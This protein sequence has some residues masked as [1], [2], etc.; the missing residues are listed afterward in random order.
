MSPLVN[1]AQQDQ[2]LHRTL[3]EIVHRFVV[4][5]F[6]EIPLPSNLNIL[7]L[8]PPRHLHSS[9]R[10]RITDKCFLTR[11]LPCTAP[12]KLL[13]FLRTGSWPFAFS[14][15]PPLMPL[16]VR[17]TSHP[18]TVCED[19]LRCQVSSPPVGRD[20]AVGPL[21][22]LPLPEMTAFLWSTFRDPDF[23]T[24]TTPDPECAFY[25]SWDLPLSSCTF[26]SER[27]TQP[28]DPENHRC[29]FRLASFILSVTCPG[30]RAAH[31]EC[32]SAN[33]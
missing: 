18:T 19:C 24:S 22:S 32:S 31:R 30:H 3:S 28:Q 23:S 11:L 21:V 7:Y 5:L 1:T 12:H 16:A 13:T 6:Q 2:L 26:S 15:S 25:L 20:G 10:P 17:T 9:L 14:L 8:I 27:M 29:I 33:S 4:S